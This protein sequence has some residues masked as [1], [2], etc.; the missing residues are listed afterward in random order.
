MNV[1]LHVRVHLHVR[2]CAWMHVCECAHAR[3]CFHTCMCYCQHS[4]LAIV[5]GV[6]DGEAPSAQKCQARVWARVLAQK[7]HLSSNGLPCTRPASVGDLCHMHANFLPHGRMDGPIPEGKRSLFDVETGQGDIASRRRVPRA[8]VEAGQTRTHVVLTPSEPGKP[9][10]PRPNVHALTHAERRRREQLEAQI[11]DLTQELQESRAVS[12]RR[13][14]ELDQL[15]A[16]VNQVR[17]LMQQLILPAAEVEPSAA[18]VPAPLA[19]AGKHVGFL[20][21]ANGRSFASEVPAQVRPSFCLPFTILSGNLADDLLSY[22][23]QDGAW[24]RPNEHWA[25]LRGDNTKRMWWDSERHEKG[26]LYNV[27]HIM[28]SKSHSDCDRRVPGGF[29]FFGRDASNPCPQRLMAFRHACVSANSDWLRILDE[30]LY[31]ASRRYTQAC[32]RVSAGQRPCNILPS[33]TTLARAEFSVATLQIGWGDTPLEKMPRH[34][35]G[36]PSLLHLSLTLFGKRI[37]DN[38]VLV[39]GSN[40]VGRECEVML[41]SL[42]CIPGSVYISSPACCY[43]SVRY[44]PGTQQDPRAPS[45]SSGGARDS[46]L[47]HPSTLA[48]HLRSDMLRTRSGPQYFAQSNK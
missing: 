2:L 23:Q 29:W 46:T 30:R 47:R 4:R 18:V 15:H 9:R 26:R 38:E 27:E 14:E 6:M 31:R 45:S 8:I 12:R 44:T 35:D 25:E 1:D 13:G 20:T 7:G 5:L 22:L 28:H 33:G 3:A 48:I 16:I 34:V 19:V 21:E 10:H 43:H 40:R 41:R 36:G 42:E 17:N 37:V 32:G 11:V 24:G 39:A